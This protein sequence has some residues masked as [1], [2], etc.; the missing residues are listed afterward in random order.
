MKTVLLIFTLLISTFS[1]AQNKKS[2]L[3][4]ITAYQYKVCKNT[5][6]QILSIP[7]LIKLSAEYFSTNNYKAFESS[8]SSVT[9]IKKTTVSDR[10]TYDIAKHT[11]YVKIFTINNL[12]KI[13]LNDETDFYREPFHGVEAPKRMG[14]FY[15]DKKAYYHYMYTQL[16]GG[17][18]EPTEK[19]KVK[20]AHYNAQQTKEKKKLI[21]GRDY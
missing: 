12:K 19:L 15:L 4:E 16:C 7:E 3:K 11:V 9:F 5:S 14:S 8:D 6:Y 1:F 21:A 10:K 18:V 2:I 17:N 13:A 20:I